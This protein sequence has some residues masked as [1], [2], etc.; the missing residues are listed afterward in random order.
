MT[1]GNSSKAKPLEVYGAVGLSLLTQAMVS[2][3]AASVPVFAPV[4][5]ADRGW[6][7]AIVALYPTTLF[8]TAFLVSFWVPQL[9]GRLGGMG[10]SVGCLALSATGLMCVLAPH[11]PLIAGAPLTAG[12]ALASM[13][14]A[15]SQVLRARTT[16][17]NAAF[18]LSIKQTGVPLGGVLAGM[19]V[20]L[21][22]ARS[23]WRDAVLILV[24]ANIAMALLLL[25]SVRWLDR[26]AAAVRGPVRNP[27][28][29]LKRL[30]ATPGM[31]PIL[32]ASFVFIGMQMC[33]R[34]FFTAYLVD[35]QKLELA[36]AGLIFSVSQ[37]AG[38][39][40]QVGWAAVA[41]RLLAA[42]WVM[43][44]LGLLISA[45]ATL[46]AMMTVDWPIYAVLGVAATFG[47]SAAAFVPVVLG[48]VARRWPAE[49]VGALTSGVQLF[50]MSGALLWPLLF[51][52]MLSQFGFSNAFMISGGC[53]FAVVL[54]LAFSNRA[55]RGTRPSGM[56]WI[57]L[58][59]A[60]SE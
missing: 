41:D 14:P 13:N 5:A 38:M 21:L 47:V 22:V 57:N 39:L 4:I 24:T 60:D 7:V 9:L 10:L 1:S 56:P 26:S 54:M 58:E 16:S 17:R 28:A 23:T 27:L 3:L 8:A 53:S 48:E 29:P 44:I 6:N 2:L 40:G 12:I 25:P 45:A 59:Q 19:L 18:I 43:A 30:L 52:A 51:G 15:S 33:L 49:D 31:P 55:F 46:T 36:D 20:P 35:S 37:G 32:L 11:I 34:T 50:F 42:R